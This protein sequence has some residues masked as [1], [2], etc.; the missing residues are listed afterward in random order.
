MFFREQLAASKAAAAVP[1]PVS[2]KLISTMS[3]TTTK[4]ARVSAKGA[5]TKIAP[6]K[7][8]TAKAAPA[9]AARRK[10]APT[11]EYVNSPEEAKAFLAHRAEE[12]AETQAR[13]R[14]F[15]LDELVGAKLQRPLSLVD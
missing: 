10:A 7:T 11:R 12:E 8:A 1:A 5:I 3:T 4:S 9:K 14:K 2:T 15:I 13:K 6:P